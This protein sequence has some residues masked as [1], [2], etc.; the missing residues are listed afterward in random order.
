MSDGF[1]EPFSAMESPLVVASN[2]GP[3]S[4]DRDEHGQMTAR[5]GTG[6][7]VTALSGV[8]FRDDITWVSAAMTAGDVEVASHGRD[9]DPEAGG[10]SRYVVIPPERYDAYYNR[11]ANEILWFVHHYLWEIA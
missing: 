5:R 8:F 11:I 1:A 9:I 2:R 7:L 6:G 4:F 3:V 10:R